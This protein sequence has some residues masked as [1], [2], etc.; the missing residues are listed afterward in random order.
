MGIYTEFDY[1]CNEPFYVDNIGF[2][3][4]PTLRD[5]RKITYRTWTTYINILVMT[6]YSYLEENNLTAK[7]ESLNKRDMENQTLFRLLLYGDTDTLF[8]MIRFFVADNLLLKFNSEAESIDVYEI[9]DENR[10]IGHIYNDNFETFRKNVKT[11]IG[12]EEIDENKPKYKSKRAQY[13]YE[14]THQANKDSKSNPN[15]TTENMIKKYCTHNKVGINILN[16]WDMTYFQFIAMFNEY[17]NGRQCDI[18]DAMAANSFSYKKTS[19]Y[20]PM[21]YMKKLN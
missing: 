21:A 20:K 2:L 9:T 6:L 8:G 1:L 10:C 17:C 13:I 4:C 15:L 7:Y 11:I 5:I 14:K 16:I 12:I 19:E 18:S 3:K